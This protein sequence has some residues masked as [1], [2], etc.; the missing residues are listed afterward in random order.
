MANLI[1]IANRKLNFSNWIKWI[2]GQIQYG[3]SNMISHDYADMSSMDFL[4]NSFHSIKNL[5][6]VQVQGT[7]H[8]L[9]PCMY[10]HLLHVDTCGSPL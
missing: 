8:L 4:K 5:H 10:M 7:Q 3:Q 2:Q 9:C 1:A 6:L